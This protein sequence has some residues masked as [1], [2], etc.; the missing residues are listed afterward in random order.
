MLIQEN[1]QKKQLILLKK[2]D[3]SGNVR[4]LRNVIERLIILGD[5]KEISEKNVKEFIK[6]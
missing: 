2:S 6:I 3:W 5:K 4:Q 1:F